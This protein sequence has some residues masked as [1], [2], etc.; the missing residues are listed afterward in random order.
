MTK[1]VVVYAAK[2]G[3]ERW[4][5]LFAER[6]PHWHFVSMDDPNAHR[7]TIALAWLP[8]SGY[9]ASLPH[10]QLICSLGMGVNGL[11]DDPHLD[12]RIPIIRLKDDDIVSQMV[13]YALGDV[14][15][16]RRQFA[17]YAAQQADRIWAPL[18]ISDAEAVIVTILGLGEIGGAI[19]KAFATLGYQVRGWRAR[20]QAMPDVSV[21]AGDAALAD[22][23]DGAHY[24][25]NVLPLNAKTQGILSSANLAP[26]ADGAHLLNIARGGHLVEQDLLKLLDTGKLGSATLDV[27]AEEPPD[28]SHPFWHH[29][30]IRLTPHIAGV[31]KAHVAATQ[32]FKTI[33]RFERD[34]PLEHVVDPAKG[35]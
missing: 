22:A 9:L 29:P 25:V 26:V 6:A 23:L 11:I 30:K 18:R 3:Y 34:L 20:P 31:T 13:E 27:L 10:L 28:H 33:D 15:S 1:P 16:R 21:Y 14:I 5:A 2:E 17:Q 32:I 35:Y 7:A 8:P 12:K 19:A 24:I 4:R